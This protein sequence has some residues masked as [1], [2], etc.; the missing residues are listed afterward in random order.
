M[1]LTQPSVTTLTDGI[2]LLLHDP[3]SGKTLVSTRLLEYAI[4]TAALAELVM[5]NRLTVD[6]DGAVAHLDHDARDPRF[7]APLNDLQVLIL[8]AITQNTRGRRTRVWITDLAPVAVEIVR[9]RLTASRI[10]LRQRHLFTADRYPAP[11]VMLA[12]VHTPRAQLRRL[13]DRSALG[14]KIEAALAVTAVIAWAVKALKPLT[15]ELPDQ[16]L[17]NLLSGLGPELEEVMKGLV[18]AIAAGAVTASR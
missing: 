4:A 6:E 8:D 18:S 12:S 7:Q 11:D 10:V 2:F 16:L 13:A 9:R 5:I 1:T 3:F 14:T 17:V 15:I